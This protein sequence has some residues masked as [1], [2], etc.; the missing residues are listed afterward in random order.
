MNKEIIGIV[1]E[2]NPL[3]NGHKRLI[4]HVKQQHPNGIVVVA[5]SG[6]FVQRG[7][8]SIYDKWDRAN[9]A[10]DNGVD[11]VVEIPPYYVLNHANI[12]ANQSIKLLNDFGVNKVY[13]GTENLE[14]NDINSIVE[15]IIN[16]KDKLE[17]L[18][19]E[20]HALPK[21]L[22]KLLGM[23]L[24]PN[25]TLGICY[26]LE[27]KE[28][29]IDVEFGRIKRESNEE[30][31]SASKLRLKIREGIPQEKDLIKSG[32]FRDIE[33]YS[34]VII[35]KLLTTDNN[36]NSLNYLKNVALKNGVKSFNQLIEQSHNK[37]FTKARLRR[38]LLQ[39]TLELEGNQDYIIL[40]SNSNGKEVLRD[41]DKYN[42]RHT[43]DN[44]DNYK[45]ERFISIKDENTLEINLGKKMILK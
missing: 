30:F 45:V 2:F 29:N 12:F 35:G 4:E 27:A 43:Q 25:D 40:A 32:S 26:V 13:F 24:N 41:I 22:E 5:M 23:E 39:F 17:E 28:L 37:S 44:N 38:D 14:I 9:S 33:E 36:S 15:V 31:T 16:N 6:Q 19:K 10:I 34:D 7:E 18:K 3:H 1:V 8:L 11:L 21:A 20:Y 42:F